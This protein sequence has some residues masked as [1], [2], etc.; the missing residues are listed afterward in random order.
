M[1]TSAIDNYCANHTSAPD[2][3]LH[4]IYRSIALHTANPNMSSSPYQGTLLQLF[5]QLTAPSVAVEIGSYAGYGAVCI[6][7]GLPNGGIL[8]V[9]EAN[10]EYEATILGHARMGGV[11]D[12]IRLHIGQ[13]LD[14]IPQL[15]DGIGLAFVDADKTNYENY[16]RRLLPKMQP[17]GLLIFDNMLWYGRVTEHPDT[18]LRCDRSTRILQ[19]LADLITA[20]PRVQNILLPVR[21]GLMVCRVVESGALPHE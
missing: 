7:R 13:A 17:G 14:I 16:Y 21:D 9:V 11:Y 8:H 3:A 18:Q 19:H 1:D 6:A 5:A 2:P 15:P 12:R 4:N 10:E 20:D